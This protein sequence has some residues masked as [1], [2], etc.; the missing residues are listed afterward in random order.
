MKNKNKKSKSKSNEIVRL[1][2]TDPDH[3]FEIREQDIFDKIRESPFNEDLKNNIDYLIYKTDSII[4]DLY[5]SKL[6]M[7]KLYQY[8]YGIRT[9][10]VFSH[11]VRKDGMSNPL[12]MDFQ[13]IIKPRISTLVGIQHDHKMQYTIKCKGEQAITISQEEE[14]I[15]ALKEI[16]NATRAFNKKVM[17]DFEFKH[18]DYINSKKS[19]TPINEFVKSKVAEQGYYNRYKPID[20]DIKKILTEYRK[21]FKSSI[22]EQSELILQEIQTKNNLKYKITQWLKDLLIA[23]RM[24][25]RCTF[26]RE[27]EVPK[28]EVLHPLFM[29]HSGLSNTQLQN[30]KECPQ[31]FYIKRMSKVDILNA[32]GHLM[33]SEQ[34]IDFYNSSGDSDWNTNDTTWDNNIYTDLFVVDGVERPN[35]NLESSGFIDMSNPTSDSFRN[36]YEVEWI[37]INEREIDGKLELVQDLYQA[38]RVGG[39]GGFYLDMGKSDKAIRSIDNPTKTQLT[40]DGVVMGDSNIPNSTLVGSLI[41]LQDKSDFINMLKE[42]MLSNTHVGGVNLDIPNLPTMLGPDFA[43]R[44]DKWLDMIRAGINLQDTSQE[45]ANP[46][47]QQIG[48]YDT[49]LNP[50]A[51]QAFELVLQKYDEKA[52]DISGI[53]R[54]MLGQFQ[55]RDGAA[56]SKQALAQ[57]SIQCKEW[58]SLLDIFVES[59]LTNSLNM[60][61]ISLTKN[62]KAL[63]NILGSTYRLF[64]LQHQISLADYQVEVVDTTG[65]EIKLERLRQLAMPLIESGGFS[66]LE[67]LEL[68]VAESPILLKARL[69]DLIR[70]AEEGQMNDS[71]GQLEQALAEIE[72][73]QKELEQSNA[74]KVKIEMMEQKRK[75]RELLLN[76]IDN[77]ENRNIKRET[78]EQKDE[79]MQ[80]RDN[81]ELEEAV[82]GGTNKEVK[83]IRI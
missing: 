36:V 14:K 30:I 57:S 6:N 32:Y 42:T 26:V 61:R 18:I 73:L 8:Y 16:F 33:S 4:N 22:Q 68:A 41:H 5:H 62:S 76:S 45:G 77:V 71:R 53:N 7:L 56:V 60:S 29:F 69:V 79:A 34:R 2:H 19:Q 21:T 51:I 38:I 78:L 28:I 1:S 37:E 81:I 75:D 23:G 40:F 46:G 63:K 65:E 39:P 10:D 49:N 17:E 55:E 15:G 74:D 25:S 54:Q 31:A 12:E 66:K 48:T 59:T 43:E 50:A 13:S 80:R 72:K 9:E 82:S 24:Y 3:A 47:Q 67:V 83:N 64:T 27:G 58:Y 11:L 70:E 52:S 35:I 44:L 20:R